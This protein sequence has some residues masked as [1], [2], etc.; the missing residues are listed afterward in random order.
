M[1]N[2]WSRR[3]H[4]LDADISPQLLNHQGCSLVPGA[5]CGAVWGQQASTPH[6]EQPQGCESTPG[7]LGREGGALRLGLGL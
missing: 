6:T 4:K 1:K 3:H 5:T 7:L 2:Y